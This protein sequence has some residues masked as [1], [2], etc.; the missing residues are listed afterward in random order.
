MATK[1]RLRF[2]CPLCLERRSGTG[3]PPLVWIDIRQ[4]PQQAFPLDLG[5]SDMPGA[6]VMVLLLARQRLDALDSVG[7]RSTTTCLYLRRQQ[8]PDDGLLQLGNDEP[9]GGAM[10]KNIPDAGC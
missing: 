7:R 8:R 6:F 9:F 1:L 10:S 5:R 4:S 3:S 2:A